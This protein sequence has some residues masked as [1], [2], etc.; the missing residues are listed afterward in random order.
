MKTPPMLSGSAGVMVTLHSPPVEENATGPSG[1]V[2]VNESTFSSLVGARLTND[3]PESRSCWAPV[4]SHVMSIGAGGGAQTAGVTIDENVTF[5]VS[6]PV[7]VRAATPSRSG[8]SGP[9]EPEALGVAVGA[10]ERPS[11]GGGDTLGP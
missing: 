4:P 11:G 5:S 1:P 9:G 6:P 8:L 2:T 10:G 7:R 3:S